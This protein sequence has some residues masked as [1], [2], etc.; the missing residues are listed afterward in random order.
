ALRELAAEPA[1]VSRTRSA[2][3]LLLI[4]GGVGAVIAGTTGGGQGAALAGAGGTLAGFVGLGP[5][6]IR[7]AAAGLGRPAPG[8]R[9][10]RGPAEGWPA[11]TR[12]ATR[13][14]PPPP[15]RP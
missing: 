7:P 3:G 2:L 14:A 4:A 5:G 15:R 10:R 1:R 8:P 13:G 11:T 9:R 12:C 6:A